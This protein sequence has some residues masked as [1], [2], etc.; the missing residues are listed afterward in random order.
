MDI[1]RQI[2]RQQIPVVALFRCAMTMVVLSVTVHHPTSAQVMESTAITTAGGHYHLANANLTW[3]VGEWMTETHIGSHIIEQGFLHP[4]TSVMSEATSNKLLT[5][6]RAKV[7][8]NPTTNIFQI[9]G[10]ASLPAHV[11][12]IDNLGRIGRQWLWTIS[13]QRFNIDLIPSGQYHL[14]VKEGKAIKMYAPISIN[15]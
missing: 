5:I 6:A 9:D 13:D 10:H 3:I 11:L 14:F 12:L 15:H 7:W 4:F 8:P 1:T 2:L